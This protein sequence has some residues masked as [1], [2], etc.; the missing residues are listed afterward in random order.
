MFLILSSFSSEMAY[1]VFYES[2]A[3]FMQK[4]VG[5]NKLTASEKHLAICDFTANNELDIVDES[6]VGPLKS[7]VEV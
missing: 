6:S 4:E 1:P 5:C 2:N 3:A 7:S